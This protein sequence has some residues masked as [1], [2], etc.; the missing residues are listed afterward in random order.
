M[1]QEMLNTVFELESTLA[2][3]GIQ[4][5]AHLYGNATRLVYN[6][7]WKKY[8]MPP[9]DAA[10]LATQTWQQYVRQRD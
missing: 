5:A 7:A 8:G 3:H 2:A 6:L 4:D 1:T 10:E 9:A